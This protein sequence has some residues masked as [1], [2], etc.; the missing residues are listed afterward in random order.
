MGLIIAIIVGGIIGWLASLIM[1]TNAQMGVLA[2][3]VVGMVGSA[4]GHFIAGILG[5]AAYGSLGSFIISL[6]GALLLIAILR[7][8]GLFR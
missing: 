6:V 1:K 4:L 3:I 5:I 2:N 7:V 8:L